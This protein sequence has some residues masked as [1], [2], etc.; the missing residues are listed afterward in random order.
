MIQ[1]NISYN[2]SHS[3]IRAG[4]WRKWADEPFSTGHAHGSYFFGFSVVG[5]GGSRGISTQKT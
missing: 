1:F 3:K 5:S 2:F 4:L